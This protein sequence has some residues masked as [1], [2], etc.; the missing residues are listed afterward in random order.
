MTRLITRFTT[1]LIILNTAIFSAQASDIPAKLELIQASANVYS[2][3]G[4]TQPPSYENNGHN[5]NLSV[6]ITDGGVVVVNG[7]DN[8]LL[9]KALHNSIKELTDQPVVAVIDENG[10]GHS[11]LG[12]SYWRELDVPIYAHKDAVH[13]IEKDGSEIL[14]RMQARNKEKAAGTFVAIPDHAVDE[15]QTLQVGSTIIEM[16]SF[17]PAHSFGDMSVWLPQQKL[18]IAGDIAFHERMLAVFPE[19]NTESWIK[20]FNKMLELKPEVVIPGHGHPTNAEEITK[21]TRDY[22]VFLREKVTELLENGDGL[23][24]AYQ[25]DQSEYSHLDTYDELA[26]KNAGRVF[27][28]L[29]FEF[30]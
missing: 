12:N 20:S 18:I 8:Y 9:A 19:T 13:E 15:H 30:F 10:Q 25:I 3:I 5:N 21:Y 2:A 16:I 6:I 1:A 28:E 22:L 14:K 26:G 11:F 7:G 23:A 17:G 24:E 27:Q 4:E 29:E